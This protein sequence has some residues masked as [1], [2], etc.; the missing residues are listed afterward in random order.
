MIAWQNI[1]QTLHFLD[2]CIYF[3]YMVVY[4]WTLQ[5]LVTV[6]E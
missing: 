6:Q 5:A 1:A 3:V 2:T 4:E